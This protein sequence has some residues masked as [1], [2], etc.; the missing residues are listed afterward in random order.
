MGPVAASILEKVNEAFAPVDHVELKN[1]SHL[2]AGHMGNPTGAPDA[3]THFKLRLVSEAFAGKKL[4][5]RHRMVNEVLKHEL[6][7]TVHALTLELK[8][9]SEGL[10]KR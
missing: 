1:Q 10:K 9:P 4:I 5:Q 8:T 6:D 2:H 7:T 3:E